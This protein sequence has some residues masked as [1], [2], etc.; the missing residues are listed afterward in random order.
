MTPRRWLLMRTVLAV[1][2]L[3]AFVPAWTSPAEAQAQYQDYVNPC[4]IGALN[5]CV[6]ITI[7]PTLQVKN[8]HPQVSRAQVWCWTKVAEPN[9][10][11]NVAGAPANLQNRD[12]SYSGTLLMPIPK[13]QVSPGQQFTLTCEIMLTKITAAGVPERTVAVASANSPQSPTD[14]NWN[15]VAAG[16]AVKWTQVVSFPAAPLP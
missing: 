16:S 5:N 2:G 6:T 15:L 9:V 14:T 10:Y 3:A 12:A 11:V 13:S 4:L 7:K 1:L 8:L